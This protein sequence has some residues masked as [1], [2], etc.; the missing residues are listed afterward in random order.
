MTSQRQQRQLTN[1]GYAKCHSLGSYK[2]LFDFIFTLHSSCILSKYTHVYMC[3]SL[4][5]AFLCAVCMWFYTSYKWMQVRLACSNGFPLRC[6]HVKWCTCVC[7]CGRLCVICIICRYIYGSFAHC[8]NYYSQ[9]NHI[10]MHE[11]NHRLWDT[12]I[13]INFTGIFGKGVKKRLISHSF[14]HYRQL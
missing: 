6:V 12:V 9:I 4:A 3:S 10:W 1:C 5:N 8:S 11:L 2:L 7:V 13:R 14:K